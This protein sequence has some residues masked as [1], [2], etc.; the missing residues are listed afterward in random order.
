MFS[1][2]KAY[3]LK[4]VLSVQAPSLVTA[5]AIA[6]L[7]YKFG[8]FLLEAIAFLATW[9]IMD[10]ILSFVLKSTPKTVESK[11]TVVD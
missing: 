5:L 3:S 10:A 8:S 1:L 9:F 7:F 6:E 4:N 11:P 2:I